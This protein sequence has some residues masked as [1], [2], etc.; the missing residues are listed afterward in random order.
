MNRLTTDQKQ[1]CVDFMSITQSN[2]IKAI[3]YLRDAGWNPENAIDRYYSNPANIT[4]P[5][6][7]KK[8]IEALFKKYKDDEDSISENLVNLIKDVNISEEFME[9]AFLWKFKA[10][11]MDSISKNEFIDAMEKTIK[12]D[13]LK[14]LGNYFVQVKQQLLSPEPNNPHFKEYYQYIYDL[15]KATN[16]KNVSLQMCIELWTIVLKPKFADIQIWFDFLNSNHKLA[17]SKDTW[18]LFL[19]FIR[20]ANDD[21]SK[22]D[23]DGAWPVLIDEFVDYYRTHK[24]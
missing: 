7:D 9:F 8:A 6:L 12:C 11:Q 20:I 24:K 4:E 16:Q 14:S 1:K 17:I 19:D 21:I 13:S 5:R 2:E 15:G 3:Q 18:N 22:Y 23:S 10:K